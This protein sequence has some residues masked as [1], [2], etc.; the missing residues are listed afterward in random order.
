MPLT[1]HLDLLTDQFGVWQ[2]HEKGRVLTD[3]GYALDDS[4][5][6]LIVYLLFNNKAKAEVC[7][8]YLEKSYKDGLM[9][10]FFWADQSERKYPSSDDALA[11]AYWAL[12]Y[13]VSHD[14]EVERARA[15][16]DKLNL[17]AILNSPF[18]RTQSYSLISASLLKDKN[19]ADRTSGKI[20]EK[21]NPDLKWFEPKLTYANAIIPYSLLM[22]KQQFDLKKERLDTIIRDSIRILEKYCRIGRIPSPIGNTIWQEIGKPHRDPFG[23][24]PIDAAF[25]VIMLVTAY[26]VFKDESYKIAAQEWLEWFYGNNIMKQ[27]LI[28]KDYACADG[29]DEEKV[30]GNYGA[31]STIMYLWAAYEYNRIMSL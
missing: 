24:Q 6:A 29:I 8:K 25:M 18:I 23:Q 19:V 10:G 31:E 1:T 30:S 2:H 16:L 3:E 27:S 7:L 20:L 9:I 5:R 13:A 15:L 4:A 22:Y 21:Y 26:E 28:N 14:F 11:L 17:D 12:A